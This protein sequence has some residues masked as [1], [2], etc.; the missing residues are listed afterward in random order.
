[1]KHLTDKQSKIRCLVANLLDKI[2]DSSLYTQMELNYIHG[3]FY[4]VS[5]SL[6]E[7]LEKRS[8]MIEEGKWVQKPHE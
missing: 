4:K 7:D 3:Q 8:D 2:E 6:E 1:M 5:D